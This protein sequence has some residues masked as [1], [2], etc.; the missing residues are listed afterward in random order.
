MN[1]DREAS[2]TI[3]Q[4]V[5]FY[6][7][8]LGRMQSINESQAQFNVSQAKTIFE[9]QAD[10]GKLREE[11]ANAR[12]E[13]MELQSSCESQAKQLLD[14]R[15]AVAAERRRCN[16]LSREKSEVESKFAKL[17][18]ENE[19]LNRVNIE[20]H[21]ERD[22]NVRA[23]RESSEAL[24]WL[25]SE[26][27]QFVGKLRESVSNAEFIIEHPK[28]VLHAVERLVKHWNATGGDD[29]FKN[30]KPNPKPKVPRLGQGNVVKLDDE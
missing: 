19:R 13:I 1:S 24:G 29:A 8:A 4:V 26:A 3:V 17:L 30:R 9:Q 23:L 28:D 25:K 7:G 20:S 11:L 27:N 22:K 16:E 6:A 14:E 21:N 2:N 5:S 10:I 12:R 18:T 15:V